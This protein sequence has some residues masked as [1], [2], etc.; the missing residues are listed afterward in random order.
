VIGSRQ[1][2]VIVAGDLA[3]ELDLEVL[4]AGLS[5][6]NVLGVEFQWGASL[7]GKTN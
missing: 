1:I 4:L 5:D 6:R 3:I 7:H 2:K